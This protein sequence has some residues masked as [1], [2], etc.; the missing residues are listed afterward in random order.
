MEQSDITFLIPHASSEELFSICKEAIYGFFPKANIL[1]ADKDRFPHWNQAIKWLW[2]NCPTDIGIFIDDDCILL[3]DISSLINRVKNGNYYMVGVEGIIPHKSGQYLRYSPHYYD[4]TFMVIDIARFKKE[5]GDDIE[6]DRELAKKEIPEG[7]SIEK[8]YGIS[9]KLRNKSIYNL[10]AE[11]SDYGEA[12][13]YGVGGVKYMIHLWYGAYKHRGEKDH[14]EIQDL[15][16]K[17][18]KERKS[19]IDNFKKQY[20][21]TFGLR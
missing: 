5:F 9:Q 8:Y 18:Y 3:E 11:L 1:V 4:M 16:I 7:R 2:D 15:F 14:K 6:V 20:E 13:T 21:T 12:T 17:D 10:Y 19:N